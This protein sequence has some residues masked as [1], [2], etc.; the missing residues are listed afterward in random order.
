M[1][2]RLTVLDQLVGS[3]ERLS[4]RV[5]LGSEGARSANKVLFLCCNFVEKPL[6][7]LFL[8]KMQ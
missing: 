1:E 7:H 6:L 5:I 2:G 4:L 3:G 8:W